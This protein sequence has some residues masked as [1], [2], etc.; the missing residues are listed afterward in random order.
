MR[1]TR[2]STRVT[3]GNPGTKKEQDGP[4]HEAVLSDG[5]ELG[6]AVAWGGARVDAH[7]GGMRMAAGCA[8][9][10]M[11]MQMRIAARSVAVRPALF[12]ANPAPPHVQRLQTIHSPV[13]CCRSSCSCACNLPKE[14]GVDIW[15]A[16]TGHGPTSSS[17]ISYGAHV[18]TATATRGYQV[19]TRT[20]ANPMAR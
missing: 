18:R 16:A 1:A 4:K 19:P 5:R 7:H 20:L 12:A 9:S 6:C 3:C 14:R 2:N 10:G 17:D 15:S 11:R 8:C 13:C